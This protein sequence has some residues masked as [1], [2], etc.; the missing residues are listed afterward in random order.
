MKRIS[1]NNPLENNPLS[2]HV[3]RFE[4]ETMARF[5]YGL[6]KN[7]EQSANVSI[8]KP[9]IRFCKGNYVQAVVLSQLIFWFGKKKPGEW[10]YKSNRELS[11][12]LCLTQ[13]QV[14]YAVA[15]LK[16]RLGAALR[17]KVKRA[18]N[19]PQ[20][21]YYFDEQRLIE[22]VL[23]D[24]PEKKPSTDKQSV[25]GKPATTSNIRHDVYLG[26]NR[27]RKS[28]ISKIGRFPC[29]MKR[30]MSQTINRSEPDPNRQIRTAVPR[31][32]LETDEEKPAIT[33]PL[34]GGRRFSMTKTELL[35]WKVRFPDVDVSHHLKAMVGWCHDNPTRCKTKAG[36][37][38][39]IGGWLRNEQR[40]MS[41]RQTYSN[42]LSP[43]EEFRQYLYSQGRE[44]AF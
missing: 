9:Y 10:L 13:E 12:E 5:D 26:K 38:R 11:E 21:H 33:L 4:S 16:K 40:R 29:Q 28:P 3:K 17:T 18:N 8:A 44:V 27:S 41:A 2:S 32:L 20:N 42:Q 19:I 7:S 43:S 35:T 36:I 1:L 31:H 14:R 39:F 30:E 6:A 23:P 34:R 22:T 15:Q 37:S 25:S 24:V